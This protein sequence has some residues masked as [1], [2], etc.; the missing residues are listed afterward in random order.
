MLCRKRKI[1]CNK[2][3][4]CSNCVRSRNAICIYENHPPHQSP[5]QHLGRDQVTDP[6]QAQEYLT[7]GYME[8]NTL[9]PSDR[10][11]ST[12]GTSVTGS[13]LSRPSFLSNSLAASSTPVSTPASEGPAQELELMRNRIKQLEEQVSR[14]NPQLS[15]PS[16]SIWT[17]NA[18]QTKSSLFGSFRYHDGSRLFGKCETIG[19]A[20]V[21]KTRLSSQSH[22]SNW[23][24]HVRFLCGI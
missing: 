11:P 24:L 8:A 7:Q 1:R 22:W 10:A 12:S 23:L 2:E 9:L 6:G 4:P 19:K 17:L 20:I 14:K 21:H 13:L 3:T 5:R 18:V 16:E 15:N